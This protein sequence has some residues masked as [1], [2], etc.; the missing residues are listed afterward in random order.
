MTTN[1]YGLSVSISSDNTKCATQEVC[2]TIPGDVDGDFNVDILDVVKIIGI[3]VSKHGDP[4]FN[5]NSDIDNDGVI[6]ILDVVV[7]TSHYAQ[8]YP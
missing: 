3:Y 8:K 7:C 5:P 4:Q 6:I 1:E 2:V